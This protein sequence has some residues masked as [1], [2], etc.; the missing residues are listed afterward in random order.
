M[1]ANKTYPNYLAGTFYMCSSLAISQILEHCP[2]VNA[3]TM[4]DVLYTGIVA[5]KANVSRSDQ[6]WHFYMYPYVSS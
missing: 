1:Y 2:V 4:E 6:R 3:I 5:E